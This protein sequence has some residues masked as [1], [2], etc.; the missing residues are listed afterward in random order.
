MCGFGLR[1]PADCR[2]G[3]VVEER[4]MNLCN[5]RSREGHSAQKPKKT[6]DYLGG[7]EQSTSQ[8]CLI[9]PNFAISTSGARRKPL[10]RRVAVSARAIGCR[11]Q[12]A[13]VTVRRHGRL[14]SRVQSWA[15]AESAAGPGTCRRTHSA[16]VV[17]TWGNAEAPPGE[18]STTIVPSAM[19]MAVV[20]WHGGS[21]LGWA[22][23][24]VESVSLS[25]KSEEHQQL[26][27]G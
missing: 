17:K 12:S 20:H 7:A 19:Y 5:R 3:C 1:Q 21:R 23:L 8:H 10:R 11:S 22:P 13:S 15:R 24:C 18:G 16:A 27:Y 14:R 25:L 9:R 4:N 2:V 26:D 6:V